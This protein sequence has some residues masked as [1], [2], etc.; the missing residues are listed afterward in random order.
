MQWSEVLT[1]NHVYKLH[2]LRLVAGLISEVTCIL[3]YSIRNYRVTN[4]RGSTDVL[5]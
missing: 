5:I 2:V 3:L 4:D 1:L